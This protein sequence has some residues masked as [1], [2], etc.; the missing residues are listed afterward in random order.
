MGKDTESDKLYMTYKVG[1]RCLWCCYFL[2]LLAFCLRHYKSI[3]VIFS[4]MT[5]IFG[6][7][8]LSYILQ[9]YLLCFHRPLH[10]L[11]WLCYQELILIFQF[12]YILWSAASYTLVFH[13]HFPY[14]KPLFCRLS[15]TDRP[16]LGIQNTA[17][18]IGISFHEQVGMVEWIFPS[19]SSSLP[20]KGFTWNQYTLGTFFLLGNMHL[21]CYCGFWLKFSML[22][23]SGTVSHRKSMLIYCFYLFEP[24]GESFWS[25]TWEYLCDSYVHTS[26]V[27]MFNFLI[28]NFKTTFDSTVPMDLLSPML[29][30]CVQCLPI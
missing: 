8:V 11:P 21:L 6:S 3:N 10:F 13:S 23:A 22:K 1:L 4:P 2:W 30:M 29:S 19:V 25:H 7:S 12:K 14:W 27:H 26:H 18:T 9:Q 17:G 28:M 15:V 5:A 20:D 24:T 16:R